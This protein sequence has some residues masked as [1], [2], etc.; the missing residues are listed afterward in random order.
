MMNI[1][2]SY[3][4]EFVAPKAVA[5]DSNPDA[6]KDALKG[7]GDRSLLALRVPEAWGGSGVSEETFFSFQEMVA[8]YSGALAFLQTQ[9]QSAAGMLVQSHNDTL[10]RQYLPYMSSGQVLVGVGFSQLR[11]QGTPPVKAVPVEGGYQLEGEVPW[12]TGWGF[13]QAFI[14]GAALPDGGGVFGIVPFEKTSQEAG[15][16]IAFSSP[17]PLAAMASTNTVTAYL[18]SWF[19]PQECVLFVKPA[20]WIQ[21]NDKKNVL[22]HGFFALGCARAGLDILEAASKTKP[23]PFI[24]EA[25]KSLNQELTTCRAVIIQDKQQHTKTFT[26]KLQLRA[27]AIDLAVRC[28]HAGVTV[29]SG[30]ANYSYHAA[31][32]V[33]REALV[34]T[35]SGQTI[36]VMEATL[37]RLIRS[38]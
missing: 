38:C 33:Y 28:A 31:Q 18:K 24:T 1:A 15:G 25:F 34:F 30:A 19:L 4:R 9:H 10:K 32:R 16:A 12:V 29:S 20:G 5:I 36:A 23:L 3:L 26:E 2:E 6:L 22:H 7:L 37:A 13:F 11:R 17:M 27:W 21:E 14:V 35:V 8:R